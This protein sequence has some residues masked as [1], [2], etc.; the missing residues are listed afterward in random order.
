VT[1][2]VARETEVIRAQLKRNGIAIYQGNALFLD[3]HTLEIQGDGEEIRVK[4]VRSWLHAVPDR[5]T[6][7]IFPLTTIAL[8]IQI[9]LPTW[10]VFRKKSSWWEQAL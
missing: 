6:P 1:A 5:R 7:Q 4:V 10:A 3:S 2:I 8:W 9:T